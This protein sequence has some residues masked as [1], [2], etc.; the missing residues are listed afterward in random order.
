[1]RDEACL[2]SQRWNNGGCPIVERVLAM[3]INEAADALFWQVA[4]REG[5]RPGHDQGRE[6]SEG[7]AGM[8]R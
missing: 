3:L 8:G 5:H 7:L 1:M 2:H 6:L 4:S